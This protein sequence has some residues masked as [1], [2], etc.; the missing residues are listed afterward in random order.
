GGDS[1]PREFRVRAFALRPRVQ[2]QKEQ[3]RAES[4]GANME[5]V[6]RGR[7]EIKTP[8]RMLGRSREAVPYQERSKEGGRVRAATRKKKSP[9]KNNLGTE[10]EARQK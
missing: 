6:T 1:K 8:Y 9:P 5:S 4:R 10:F 3:L 2:E 7:G